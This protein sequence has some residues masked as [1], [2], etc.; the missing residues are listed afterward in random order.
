MVFR[1]VVSQ[2][3][4]ME[5]VPGLQQ[6][7][8]LLGT[9]SE[10]GKQPEEFNP[11]TGEPIRFKWIPINVWDGYLHMHW[12]NRCTLD[13]KSLLASEIRKKFPQG[14]CILISVNEELVV[15]YHKPAGA[16]SGGSWPSKLLFM[17]PI[18]VP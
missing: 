3:E 17:K 6:I 4:S 18:S 15:V 16:D 7:A 8:R 2:A 13:T 12:M 9:P 1:E 11:K 5:L 14:S 10:E